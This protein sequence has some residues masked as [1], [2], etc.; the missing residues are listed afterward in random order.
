MNKEIQIVPYEP[1]EQSMLDGAGALP[2]YAIAAIRKDIGIDQITQESKEP[3]SPYADILEGRPRINAPNF[4]ADLKVRWGFREEDGTMQIVKDVIGMVRKRFGAP[5]ETYDQKLEAEEARGH[6]EAASYGTARIH[7]HEAVMAGMHWD[8][9]AG[10]LGVVVGEKIMK[11]AQLGIRHKLPLITFFTSGGAR[12]QEN[13]P[14]LVQMSRTTH[15]VESHRKKSKRGSVG[16][17]LYQTWGGISASAFPRM[18]ITAALRGTDHGFTG[19]RVIESYTYEPVPDG[20]QTGEMSVRQRSL[21]LVID[22]ADALDQWLGKF[23]A[24]DEAMYKIRG[25]NP[26]QAMLHL[27][28]LSISQHRQVSFENQGFILPDFAPPLIEVNVLA[29]EYVVFSQEQ[30]KQAAEEPH[31]TLFEQY[32]TLRKDARRPDMEYIL[33][34]AFTNVVP[35]YS[36]EVGEDIIRNPA[37]GA[38]LAKIENQPFLVI[39]NLPSYQRI[40][41]NII[42]IPSSPGPEDFLYMQ[43]MLQFGKELGY[44]VIFLT[45]TL[46]AKPTLA[47]ERADQSRRIS[48]SIIAGL[49]YPHPVISVVIGALGS[50][51]G[52]ATTP[53]GD[54][55]AMLEGAMTFVAEPVSAASI[56][57]NKP[58]PDR[59]EVEVT[60]NTMR[61]TAKDQLE[62]KLIDAVIPEPTG[63][64][65]ENPLQAVENLR[66][67]IAKVAHTLLGQSNWKRLRNRDSRIVNLRG[68]QLKGVSVEIAQDNSLAAGIV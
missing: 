38:A 52:M 5:D 25:K 12:Q 9:F 63:G 66:D 18:H 44:P 23:L 42:K 56:L 7:G 41:D 54:H 65:E 67:H 33:A 32:Q 50:G 8:F 26:S 2:Q 10:S 48:D 45:D 20:A 31:K 46:G 58:N 22:N 61:A 1:L 59:E 55:V 30:E 60:I 62:L 34:N 24:L 57:Y 15:A 49:E 11:A 35:L 16:I 21:D 53:M 68:F 17:A 4:L 43:R 28:H 37:I 36:K 29:H 47:A 64:A 51:G 19:K 3:Q 40:G 13:F 6:T 39:G 14:G 27:P